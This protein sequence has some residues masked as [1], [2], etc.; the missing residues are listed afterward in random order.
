MELGDAAEV[1]GELEALIARHPLRE[2]MW[3]LL[4]TAL[5]RSNRQADALA[6][7]QR[8]RTHLSEEMGLVPGPQLQ[9]LE[10]QVLVQ[11]PSLDG[12]ARG[13]A[14]STVVVGNLPALTSPLVGRDTDLREISG[15]LTEGRLVSV[16]GPAGVGKTRLAIEI[17]RRHQVPGGA[18]LVRLDTTRAPSAIPQ[19]VGAAFGLVGATE[20][21]ILDRIRA[22]EI[23]VVLDNC[24]H[25]LEPAADL[26]ARLLDAAPHLRILVTSQVPLGLDGEIVYTV[27]PL[28]MADSMTLF[29][30][31]AADRR[32]SFRLDADTAAHHVLEAV[33]D[34]P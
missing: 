26:C 27:E 18:W 15:V 3:V 19:V 14:A 34:R 5:Y 23:V 20:A 6:A 30:Q 31:R 12:T 11:D 33:R 10:R 13:P 25:V 17:A 21:M 4:I 22:T 8:V 28:A 16:V 1:I 29:T 32:T 7:Y 24:E 9:A 2:S